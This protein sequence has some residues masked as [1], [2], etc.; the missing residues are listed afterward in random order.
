MS[1]VPSRMA[2]LMNNSASTELANE[3]YKTLHSKPPKLYPEYNK[4]KKREAITCQGCGAVVRKKKCEYCGRLYSD[5]SKEK[6]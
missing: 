3:I 5:S 2:K 6:T 4:K 1:I